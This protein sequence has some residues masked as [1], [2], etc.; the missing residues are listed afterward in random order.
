MHCIWPYG[1]CM[2]R[3]NWVWIVII[4]GTIGVWYSVFQNGFF[5]TVIGLIIGSS[6]AGII[7]KLRED[8]RV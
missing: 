7:I 5:T 1:G 8:T 3:I 6:I 2:K 4:L